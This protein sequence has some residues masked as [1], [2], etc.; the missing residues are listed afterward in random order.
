VLGCS[1]IFSDIRKENL[2]DKRIP[3]NPE[4]MSTVPETTEKKPR[5]KHGPQGASATLEPKRMGRPPA[6]I[7]GE[8]VRT[9]AEMQCT[10]DEMA[11]F[12]KVNRDTIYARFSDE[13]EKGRLVGNIS[14]R[15]KMFHRALHGFNGEGDSTMLIWLSKQ[16][17]GHKDR[18]QDEV[19]SLNFNVTVSEIPQ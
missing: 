9:L 6:N 5:R 8:Q 4:S 16:Y 3:S 17:L 15:R 2:N 18:S 19:V 11:A 10:V 7:D 13:L 14:L 12:F 1:Q